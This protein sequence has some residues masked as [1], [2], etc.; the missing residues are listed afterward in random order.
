M[1][2]RGGRGSGSLSG[3]ASVCVQAR[4]YPQRLSADLADGGGRSRRVVRGGP[5]ARAGASG[6]RVDSDSTLWASVSARPRTKLLR[7]LISG[8]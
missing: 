5:D 7:R 2:C 6:I 1:V 4:A 3:L 8:P